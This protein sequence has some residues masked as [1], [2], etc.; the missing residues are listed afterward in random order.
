[1]KAFALESA[2][3]NFLKSEHKQKVFFLHAVVS[4]KTWR[5]PFQAPPCATDLWVTVCNT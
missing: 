2:I 4:E 1:M 5:L 3:P